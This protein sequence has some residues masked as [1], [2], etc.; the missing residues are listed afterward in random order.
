MALSFNL[1]NFV[2]PNGLTSNVAATDGSGI[3]SNG[4]INTKT[5]TARISDTYIISNSMLNEARFGWFKDRREQDI[6]PLLAPPDGLLSGLTVQGQGNLGVSTNLPNVQPSEDRYQYA[7]SLSWTKGAHQFKFGLDIADLRD[8]E[9]ALFNGPG[10][11]TYGSI[12]AFAE[13]FSGVTTGKHWNSFTESFGPLTDACLCR[14]L[15][16]LR[17]GSVASYLASD[18][19][20][21]FAL[22]VQHLHPA[23]FECRT[24]RKPAT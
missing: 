16:S 7:D 23:A 18:L 20:L 5:R 8:T 12:T 11:Y 19:E 13:D 17:A 24:I 2:S 3:G 6:N 21:R 10:S 15:R 1:L 4:N 14:E 9:N 22:R